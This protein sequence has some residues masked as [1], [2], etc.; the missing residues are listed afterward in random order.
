VIASCVDWR[1]ERKRTPDD[2]SK[3]FGDAETGVNSL[4]RDKS[5]EDAC[6]LSMWCPV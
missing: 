5:M 2:A 3:H 1:D 4:F 6:L